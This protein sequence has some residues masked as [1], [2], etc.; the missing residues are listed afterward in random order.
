MR[1]Q[2][3]AS[4]YHDWNERITAECYAPN[5]AS[6]ILDGEQ[7]IARI[8]NNYARISFNFG[9][10]LLSLAGGAGAGRLPRDPRGRPREPRALLRPRLRHGPGLQ[11]HDHAAGEPRATSGRRCCWGIARLRAPLRP[12]PEGMWLP[13]TAVDIESLELLAEQGIKFTVLAPHQASACDADRRR[14]WQDVDGGRSIPPCAYRCALPSGRSIAVFFYDGPI[15]RAVAFE[16]LLDSGERFADR[17][18][19]AFSDDARDWPQLVHIATDGE[20][21]GHHHRHGDMAL[22]YALHYIESQEAG[23]QLTNYGEFL[24]K[25]PPT[26]EVEI[27]REHLLELRPRRRALA[28]RLR[29]Q[30]RRHAGLEPGL[31]RARCARRSTGCATRWRRS[32]SS[33]RRRSSHDPWA[34]RDDYIDVILDRSPDNRERFLADARQ[35]ATSTPTSGSRRSK[36]LETAAPRH[37]HVHELRLVLRR[38]LRH[39]DGAGDPVRRPRAAARRG[40]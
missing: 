23:A 24:E 5:A 22:A 25:H 34:A 16:G 2:D 15:S 21:Y 7:R 27:H 26:H 32:S 28:E 39:R 38:D 4:P 33:R 6:R 1:V 3:S 11:P 13:E 40:A 20:T 35:R 29:L 14:D 18:L 8:V 19:G 30:L 10:T 17:L 36:L 12:Q 9:P 31:A 37:A